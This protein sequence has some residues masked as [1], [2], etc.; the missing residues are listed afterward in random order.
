MKAGRR[1]VAWAPLGALGLALVLAGCAEPTTGQVIGAVSV[2]GQPA[3]TGSI[4]FIPVGG[5]GITAGGAIADGQYAVEAALGEV[6]VEIRVPKVV[7][8]AALYDTPDSRVRQLM[9]ETLPA[10]Y[11]DRSELRLEVTPGE[12]RQDYDLSTK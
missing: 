11:N 2:D 7:G 4:A 9:A 6:K 10:K 5:R 12:T 8:E 1:D 3:K